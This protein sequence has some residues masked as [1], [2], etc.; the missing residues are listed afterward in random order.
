MLKIEK[1]KIGL[2]LIGIN[3]AR[4]HFVNKKLGIMTLSSWL[5]YDHEIKQMIIFVN[6]MLIYVNNIEKNNLIYDNFMLI[7]VN[8]TDRRTDKQTSIL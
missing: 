3:D 7:Y 1:K 5:N 2:T 4:F 8:I 6:V